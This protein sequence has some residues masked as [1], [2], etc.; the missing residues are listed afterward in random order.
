M[1]ITASKGVFFVFKKAVHIGKNEIKK[2]KKRD[3]KCTFYYFTRRGPERAYQAPHHAVFQ[4]LP[5]KLKKSRSK[6][7]A[8]IA[9]SRQTQTQTR[10][11]KINKMENEKAAYKRQHIS[12]TLATHWQHSLQ[13][14]TLFT[15][16][17]APS[18]EI[19]PACWERLSSFLSLFCF[20]IFF[21]FH[22]PGSN[23]DRNLTGLRETAFKF[24]SRHLQD[25]VHV[26]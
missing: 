10:T 23:V 7:L 16:L 21:F 9:T 17:A 6:L 8:L 15:H 19:L 12:N 3:L 18:T 24:F 26:K 20:C 2:S 4:R 14:A 1:P 25:V 13:K 22:V 5:T 11:Q